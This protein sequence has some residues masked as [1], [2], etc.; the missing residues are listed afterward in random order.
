M[1]LMALGRDG[2]GRD[3][4]VALVLAVLVVDEDHHLA[5]ADILERRLHGAHGVRG[6]QE[7]GWS[8]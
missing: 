6:D 5:G 1:K 4:E 8:F 7:P 2:L 3:A